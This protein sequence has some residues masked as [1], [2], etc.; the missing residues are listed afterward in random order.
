MLLVEAAIALA[1]VLLDEVGVAIVL[2]NPVFLHALET[3][4]SLS[5]LVVNHESLEIR[6]L[7]ITSDA[8]VRKGVIWIGEGGGLRVVIAVVVVRQL[9]EQVAGAP[10]VLVVKQIL[11][12]LLNVPAFRAEVLDQIQFLG[13]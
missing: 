9:G 8:I 3:H 12:V 1:G 5:L 2:H 7:I 13:L 10:R 4:A 6:V 11:V